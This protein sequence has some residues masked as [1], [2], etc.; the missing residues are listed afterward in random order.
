MD[1]GGE[2][3]TSSIRDDDP[4]GEILDEETPVSKNKS[5]KRPGLVWHVRD[6]EDDGS[7]SALGEKPLWPNDPL[8]IAGVI[9][10]FTGS[11]LAEEV[12]ATEE[13]R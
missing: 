13:T 10:S 5:I 12:A 2:I 7:F 3:A 9:I 1:I 4:F 6:V 11:P 8:R